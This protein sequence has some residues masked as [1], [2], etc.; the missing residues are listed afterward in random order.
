MVLS[1]NSEAKP[2]KVDIGVITNPGYAD[3]IHTPKPA[4][5]K[6]GDTRTDFNADG[7]TDYIFALDRLNGHLIG[8]VSYTARLNMGDDKTKRIRFRKF[9]TIEER[10]L[11]AP[12]DELDCTDYNS[13]NK[14]LVQ[15]DQT[16]DGVL[17]KFAENYVYEYSQGK[18]P[19]LT[20]LP[21][22][23]LSTYK[24]DYDEVKDEPYWK[25]V[26]EK[27]FDGENCDLSVL[28]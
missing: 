17:L 11:C 27:F 8:H 16:D 23:R 25:L 6:G 3:G 10:P 5:I 15:F 22:T 7:Q 9:Y 19:F 26:D 1:T 18:R 14:S 2:V 4:T 13:C 28:F 12:L 20:H 21:K 24:V